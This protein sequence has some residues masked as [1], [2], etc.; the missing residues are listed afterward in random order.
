GHL[1][2]EILLLH[3]IDPRGQD[4]HL[5]FQNRRAEV[6][7]AARAGYGRQRR[8]VQTTDDR[9][10]IRLPLVIHHLVSFIENGY[11]LP[12]RRP[13]SDREYDNPFFRSPLG[14]GQRVTTQ[15]FSVGQ[16]D[17]HLVL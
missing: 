9:R 6:L 2:L 11:G 16:Q 8:L 4:R 5:V 1:G 15:V 10:T 17:E 14:F 3:A 13:H 7:A 12:V